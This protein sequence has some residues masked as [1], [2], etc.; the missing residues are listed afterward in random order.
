MPA[1]SRRFGYYGRLSARNRAIYRRSDAITRL[2]LPEPQ[3]LH[4]AV[5]AIADALAEDDRRA[6]Q[7]ATQGLATQVCRALS[8]PR[9]ALRVLARRPADAEGE[10]HG[11]YVRHE[12]GRAYIRVWMRTAAHERVVAFR[13]FLRTLL[14]ELCHHLDYE[15]LELADSYHTKGFFQRESS[16]VRQLAP[17]SLTP[18]SHHEATIEQLSLPGLG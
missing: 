18:P 5:V 4:P 8:A 6:V 1:G 2:D 16:L 15:V 13:T 12:D 3:A 17:A 7:R 10:L 11:L 14:H 9:V